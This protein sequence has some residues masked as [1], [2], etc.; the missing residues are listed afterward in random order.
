MTNLLDLIQ[1][2][3]G[4]TLI[5]QAGSLLNENESSM[6]K[7]VGAALPSLMGVLADKGSSE[8]GAG[9]LMDMINS[10]GFD[11][12]MLDNLGDILG[13]GATDNAGLDNMLQQG[14]NILGSLLGGNKQSGLIDMIANFAGIGKSSS[15]S[16]LKMA[17][18]LLLSTI[19]KQV[20]KN[21]LNAGGLMK[22]LG[23]QT[24][25]IKSAMPAG[26]AGVGNLLGLSGPLG[27]L[28]AGAREAVSDVR[29]TAAATTNKSRNW[30]PYLLLAV[31]AIAAIWWF[32]RGGGEEAVEEGVAKTGQMAEDAAEKTQEVASEMAADVQAAAGSVGAKL[33]SWLKSGKGEGIFEFQHATFETGSSGI[34]PQLESEIKTLAAIMKNNPSMTVEIAGHTDNTGDAADNKE[35]SML[36]AQKIKAMLASEGVEKSRIEANGYGQAKPIAGNDTEEGREKNRRVEVKVLSK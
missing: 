5:K 6:G 15:G 36:R 28:G 31:L 17:A 26:L 9:E 12:S 30:L 3:V 8:S 7:A 18:P 13:G 11:G 32:T 33:Q 24:D 19:G 23:G 14:G 20:M 22:L 1:S 4:D 21:G 2:Q 34:S 35:L 10:G 25:F 27:D 16:L 29:E